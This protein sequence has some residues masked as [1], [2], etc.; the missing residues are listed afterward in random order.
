MILF[1]KSNLKSLL[2]SLL[3]LSLMGVALSAE[4]KTVPD[5]QID[6]DRR[7]TFWIPLSGHGWIYNGV[8]FKINGEIPEYAGDG[9]P[10]LH[11]KRDS[12]EKSH[13]LIR[14]RLPGDYYLKFIYQDFEPVYS[15]DLYFQAE[16]ES[17]EQ[18]VFVRV[19]DSR[20]EKRDGIEYSTHE[21]LSRLPLTEMSRATE[22]SADNSKSTLDKSL[23]T[24]DSLSSFNNKEDKTIEIA[25]AKA[26]KETEA[27]GFSWKSHMLFPTS[28][29]LKSLL[30]SEGSNDTL[31]NSESDEEAFKL[32]LYYFTRNSPTGMKKALDWFQYIYSNYPAS[33]YAEVAEERAEYIHNYYMLIR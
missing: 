8:D 28:A 21:P 22:T 3:F 10:V 12:E 15:D 23:Q 29:E 9:D 13:F 6:L 26:E 24:T 11:G 20:K 27:G 14:F 33:Q 25:A 18:T 19:I 30:E 2:V 4:Q 31:L 17:E 32:G 16:P 5:Y 7:K 1:F